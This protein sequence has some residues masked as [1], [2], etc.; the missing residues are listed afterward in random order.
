MWQHLDVDIGWPSIVHIIMNKEIYQWLNKFPF[1]VLTL[2]IIFH[3]IHSE[4][5]GPSR[6][7]THTKLTMCCS[8]SAL[9]NK[10]HFAVYSWSTLLLSTLL[11]LLLSCA[12]SVCERDMDLSS[13]T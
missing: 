4:G 9:S 12:S 1:T 5:N 2:V 3:N 13:A 8:T 6:C 7:N 11:L 10:T